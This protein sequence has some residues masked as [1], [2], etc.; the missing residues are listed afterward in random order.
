MTTSLTY[1]QPP[2]YPKGIMTEGGVVLTITIICVAVGAVAYVMWV[3]TK[4]RERQ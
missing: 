1:A 3:L 2:E 4:D